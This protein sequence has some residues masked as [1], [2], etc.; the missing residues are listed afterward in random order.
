MNDLEHRWLIWMTYVRVY[1]S[2][3]EDV[4]VRWW[5]ERLEVQP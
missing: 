3:L 5:L 4:R 1:Q 2:R